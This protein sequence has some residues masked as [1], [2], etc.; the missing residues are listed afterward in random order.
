MARTVRIL[1]YFQEEMMVQENSIE[2]EKMMAWSKKKQTQ[3]VL[4]SQLIR[5]LVD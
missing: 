2:L 3:M 5:V 1:F 4:I